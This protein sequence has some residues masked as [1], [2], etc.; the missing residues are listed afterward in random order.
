MQSLHDATNPATAA[1]CA[2]ELLDVVPA[3]M[4]P[5]RQQMRSHRAAGLS[6]PQFR[7]LCFVERYD[8]ASLSAVADHLD[9]SLPTV[10]RMVNGL[11]ERGYMQRRSS[12][13]DR[14]HVSLSLRARG[15]SVMREARTATQTFL[16]QK[17]RHLT[18]GQRQAMVTAMD[19]LREVFSQ[20][21]PRPSTGSGQ[22]REGEL[23]AR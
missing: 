10:S 20:D 19:A 16:M 13:D 5:L 11:V 14:R 12:E 6:V 3:V 18:A 7:A 15:Q 1:E 21:M 8:G 23:V 22:A 2:R 9:L 4:R 17:L